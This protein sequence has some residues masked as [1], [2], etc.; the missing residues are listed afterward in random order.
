VTGSKLGTWSNVG[1]LKAVL[2]EFCD[3]FLSW[4]LG[5]VLDQNYSQLAILYTGKETTNMFLG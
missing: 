3:Y 2:A 1:F 4:M 5:F